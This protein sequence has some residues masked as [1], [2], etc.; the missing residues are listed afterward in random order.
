[1][2]INYGRADTRN[3][4]LIGRVSLVFGEIERVFVGVLVWVCVTSAA[5]PIKGLGLMCLDRFLSPL[6]CC[7]PAL[8]DTLAVNRALIQQT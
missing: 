1:M 4:S 8:P 5:L 7:G 6:F 3:R 2:L